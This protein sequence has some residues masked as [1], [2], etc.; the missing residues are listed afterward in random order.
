M[1]IPHIRPV[2]SPSEKRNRW[3]T[4][5]PLAA[6]FIVATLLSFYTPTLFDDWQFMRI[7]LDFNDDMHTVSLEA[8]RSY[9]YKIRSFDNGRL[10]NIMAPLFGVVPFLHFIF[11]LLTGAVV[12]CLAY[13]L[14]RIG[15]GHRP[16]PK[17]MAM[18][19]A[20]VILILPWRDGLFAT[21]YTLN[22]PYSAVLNLF[23]IAVLLKALRDGFTLQRTLLVLLL[24]IIVGWWH[25]GFSLTT[26]AGGGIITIRRRFHIS[27]QWYLIAIVCLTSTLI[28]LICPGMI[29]RM[30][31]GVG[32][33]GSLGKLHIAINMAPVLFMLMISIAGLIIPRFRSYTETVMKSD[34]YLMFAS[35]AIFGAIISLSVHHS[36]R[37]SFWPACASMAAVWSLYAGGLKPSIN[38]RR[39]ICAGA[40]AIALAVSLSAIVWQRRY[41]LEAKE[42]DK[43]IQESPDGVVYYDIIG[44][45]A[46]PPYTLYIPVRHGWQSPCNMIFL[47]RYLGRTTGVVPTALRSFDVSESELIDG[48]AGMRRYKNNLIYLPSGPDDEIPY[49]LR[50]TF[51]DGTTKDHPEFYN[52]R[53]INADSTELVYQKAWKVTPDHVIRVDRM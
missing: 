13:M 23:F 24:A 17:S 9:M 20:L 1:H 35:I 36:V 7:Y 47:S 40:V 26:I 43:L 39:V 10:S 46:C 21:D 50:Y 11:P 32:P 8:L 31:W 16:G 22:Y 34:V 4:I 29:E 15:L 12:A 3:L 37:T 28:A 44:L 27:W 6:I 14:P 51:D 53:F 42:V 30:G 33:S 41:W 5:I 19:A 2:N 25:E 18:S 52:M 38:L 45:E 49:F 48:T